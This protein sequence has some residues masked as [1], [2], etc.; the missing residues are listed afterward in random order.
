MRFLLPALLL[1]AIL[2]LEASTAKK[3]R[4][5]ANGIVRN[6]KEAKQIAEVDTG[7]IAVSARKTRMNGASCGWEVEVHMPKED[8]GWLCFVDCDTR[9][10]R[11]KDRIPNPPWK[12]RKGKG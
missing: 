5:R 9:Q 2:P 12:R 1:L 10:V 4:L 7:G 8:R 3:P 11:T 6:I